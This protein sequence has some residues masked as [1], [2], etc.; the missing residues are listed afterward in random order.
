MSLWDCTL[1]STPTE[2]QFHLWG[3]LY[4]FDVI[5]LGIQRTAKKNLE[6]AGQ[7]TPEHRIRFASKVMST[8]VEILQEF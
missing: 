6:L 2:Q 8:R 7:M 5:Q 3:S 1:T 4:P